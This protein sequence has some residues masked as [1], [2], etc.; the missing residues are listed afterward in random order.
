MWGLINYGRQWQILKAKILTEMSEIH[1]SSEVIPSVGWAL[2]NIVCL[3]TEAGNDSVDLGSFNQGLDCASYVHVVITLAENLL[4]WIENVG[5]V[6]KEKQDVQIDVSVE[7]IDRSLC[8]TETTHGSLKMSYIDLL[9]PV[10][11]QWHLTNLLA[12]MKTDSYTHGAETTP[13]NNIERL[14]K[15]ELLDIAYLYSYML[16]IFSVLNPTLGSLPVLNMLSFTPG[17]LVNLWGA[18]EG[19]LFPG[20]GH[21]AENNHLCISKNSK[22]EKD[23]VFVKKQ[24]G[25]NKDGVNMWVNVLNKVTGKSQAGVDLT[26][27]HPGT[28]LVDEDSCDVWD[29]E[30]L[31]CGPQGISKDLTCLLH[32]FCS[33]YSHLLLI[34][35]DIE[36]YEKQ[37]KCF[38]LSLF[39]F[40]FFG[41]LEV[42]SDTNFLA[43]Y[44]MS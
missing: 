17:F 27:G 42:L 35:D 24:K 14:G 3:T 44:N 8:E 20:N 36:F 41:S 6:R 31:R 25:A 40:L 38:S 18:L 21:V 33:T 26:D 39:F 2:A 34:L 5:W 7:P 30:H 29:I 22:K 11:Q 10:C 16:R 32:L 19:I 28:S 4:G 9:R 37:V 23:A 43:F 13:P 1:Y 12:I 15:F